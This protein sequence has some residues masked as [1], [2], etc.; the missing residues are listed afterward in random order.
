MLEDTL[1]KAQQAQQAAER[2]LSE[3]QQPEV[4]ELREQ[5]G[6][7]QRECRRLDCALVEA[8]RERRCLGAELEEARRQ[9]STCCVR[10]GM[11]ALLPLKLLVLEHAGVHGLASGSWPGILRVVCR[12]SRVMQTLW[13]ST[14]IGDC[15]IGL[16]E[17]LAGGCVLALLLPSPIGRQSIVRCQVWGWL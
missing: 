17:G 13:A 7:V 5:L 8:Q 12:G 6:A 16:F 2:A 1:L 14:D 11:S 4:E 9:V 15:G 3:G 10:W